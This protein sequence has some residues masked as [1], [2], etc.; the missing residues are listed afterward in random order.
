MNFSKWLD[1]P[2]PSSFTRFLLDGFVLFPRS[3]VR[4]LTVIFCIAVGTRLGSFLGKK[5]H[6]LFG[7]AGLWIGYVLG[8]FIVLAIIWLIL[9]GK[10][11]LFFPF[12]CCRRGR[13]HSIDN[14]GWPLGTFYGRI[15]WRRFEYVCRCG[16]LYIRQGTR[17]MQ[18]LPNGK[19]MP[20]KR[21]TGFRKW[22]NDLDVHEDRSA[23]RHGHDDLDLPSD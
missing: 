11:L 18:I 9:L 10:I 1:F 23:G 4:Q 8:I 19:K 7:A 15:G 2:K 3:V 16:D 17:F 5:L 12:P 14:Y 13:C 21:L 6:D 20:Y 22:E